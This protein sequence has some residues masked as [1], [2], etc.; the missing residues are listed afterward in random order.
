MSLLTLTFN[1]KTI[2]GTIDILQTFAKQ[3]GL[4]EEMVFDKIIM[5]R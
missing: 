3:L 5:M 4:N 2:I 1:K